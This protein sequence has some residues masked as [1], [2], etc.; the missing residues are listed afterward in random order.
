M[1]GAATDEARVPGFVFILETASQFE[2]DDR[3]CLCCLAGVSIERKYEGYL[4][5]KTW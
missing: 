1:I 4:D 2:L 5:E 3:S